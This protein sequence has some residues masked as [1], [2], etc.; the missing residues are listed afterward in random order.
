MVMKHNHEGAIKQLIHPT[1]LSSYLPWEANT[2]EQTTVL[3]KQAFMNI[4]GS[5][6]GFLKQASNL[7]FKIRLAS[8]LCTAIC[9]SRTLQ[10]PH[11]LPEYK[12]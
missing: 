1:L 7:F 9:S 4:P 3:T 11:P 12:S 6:T 2:A 5:I 10:H 8:R